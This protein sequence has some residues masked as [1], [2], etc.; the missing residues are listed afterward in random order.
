MRKTILLLLAIVY[1]GCI[2][3]QDLII[4]KKSE[5]IEAKVVEIG[6]ST[7]K[8][9][10]WTYQEGPNYTILKSEISSILYQN[11]DVEVFTDNTD[12]STQPSV[13]PAV[14]SREN[15][16]NE[17]AV[18]PRQE[19]IA[20]EPP[21][22]SWRDTCFKKE[23]FNF[24]FTLGAA[25]PLGKYGKTDDADFSA[26][27]SYYDNLYDSPDAFTPTFGAASK[28]GALFGINF[29]I[30]VFRKNHHIIALL[31]RSDLHF[32]TISQK[33]KSD[34][35]KYELQ[36]WKDVGDQ[37]N[38]EYGVNGYMYQMGNFSSYWDCALR[39]GLDYTWY[40][41]K[42][43]GFFING[44]MGV[45]MNMVSRTKLINAM[46]GTVMG[47]EY[48]EVYD[49]WVRLYSCN[50]MYYKYSPGFSFAY[51]GSVGVLLGDVISIGFLYSSGTAH[52]HNMKLEEYYS[53]HLD[54]PPTPVSL[55]SSRLRTQYIAVL[56]GFHL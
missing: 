35:I 36:M 8:Y 2:Y 3:S 48:N 46:G 30:P 15:P 7:V 5:R 33:E 9:K 25:F 38:A 14:P 1:A 49:Q 17:E 28:V 40:L 23:K 34:F 45:Q 47:T 55:V 31:I 12:R 16:M 42:N 51:E 21:E 24:Y 6:E 26:I 11:G 44:N 39:L 29:H 22:V 27:Y 18:S 53:G 50:G 37:I 32:S 10:K 54:I 4:T 52:K 13:Q 43:V 19:T 56:L 41:N 20:P